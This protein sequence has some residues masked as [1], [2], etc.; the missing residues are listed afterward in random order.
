MVHIYDNTYL[1]E[2]ISGIGLADEII[3]CTNT[4]TSLLSLDWNGEVNLS[5]T[6]ELKKLSFYLDWADR[7]M[8]FMNLNHFFIHKF[9]HY[10]NYN[11]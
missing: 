3:I 11:E 2:C 1:I 5:Q 10:S 8:I 6:I 7:K 9:S 4:P